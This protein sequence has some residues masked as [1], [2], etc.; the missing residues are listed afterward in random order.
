M[1]KK[2]RTKKDAWLDAIKRKNKDL[3]EKATDVEIQKTSYKTFVWGSN[4]HNSIGMSQDKL[5]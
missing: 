5:A 2:F 1:V 4:L 3:L